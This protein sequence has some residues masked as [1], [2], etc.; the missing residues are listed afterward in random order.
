MSCPDIFRCLGL[1]FFSGRMVM[2]E[3]SE[4]MSVHLMDHA[5]PGGCGFFDALKE[6][7]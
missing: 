3:R 2:R 4:L 5:S 6:C 7:S 1:L